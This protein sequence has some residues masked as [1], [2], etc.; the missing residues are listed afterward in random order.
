MTVIEAFDLAGPLPH[1]RLAIE[2]SAGTGKTFTLATLAARYVAEDGVPIGELLIVTFTRAAAAELKDRVR[3][4]LV[5]F[6]DALE[7]ATEPDDRLLTQIRSEDRQ[8]RLERVRTAI[9][10]FDAATITTI[11]GFA[12]QVI[13]TLGSTVLTD[14]D[15]VLVDDTEA[16]GR[17]VATDL[18]VAEAVHEAHPADEIPSLAALRRSSQLALNN[19]ESV[20]LP[21]HDPDESSPRAARLRVLV[22]EIGAE[23]DRR[24]KAAGT[25]AFDDLLSRLRDALHDELAGRG[26]REA[27]RRRYRVALIDEFQDTDPV[28]WA[29]FDTVFGLAARHYD[30]ADVTATTMVLVGDPKQAI[31][32]FRGANVHTYIEAAHA[33]DTHLTGLGVNWRS[34]PAVL[35]ATQTL[36]SGVTFGSDNI[37]FQPVSAPPKHEGRTFTTTDGTPIPALS[38]R[39]TIGPNVARDK[40]HGHLSTATN[41]EGVIHRELATHIR[42]LLE[43]A[44][45]PDGDNNGETRAL[46]PDDV[47]VLIA[48]NREGP[49]IRDALMALGIP[50]VITRGD[51]VLES[52][53]S[54]HFH[55]LLAAVARPADVRRARAA[56]LSWFFG[57]DA[58]RVAAA[59]DAELSAVQVQL[60][61]WGETLSGRGVAA[62]VGQVWAET[63]VASRVLALPDGDRAMTDLD[64]IAE[65]LSLS[66]GRQASPTTL[67][68]TFETLAGGGDD[69]NPEAD[70]AARRVESESRAVQ[71][72]TTFVAKGLEYPVVCCTS[73][74]F[75]SGAKARDNIWWD[76]ATKRRT[77]DVATH[78]KWGPDDE[79]AER[80]MLAAQ[81]AVGSHLRVLYV[82]L[83]RARHHTAVWWLPTKADWKTGL[84]RVLFARDETGTIDPDLFNCAELDHIDVDESLARLQP[85]VDV[86]DGELEVVVVD[87]PGDSAEPWT[88]ASTPDRVELAVATLDHRLDR[89]RRRWSFT[90]ITDRTHDN[91]RS[92]DPFDETAG[93]AD[94]TD[95]G[96]TEAWLSGPAD[97]MGYDDSTSATDRADAPLPLGDI[98]GG[99]GFGTLVHEVLE[100]ID[101]TVAD[102]TTEIAE[103]VTDRLAWNPWPV[104]EQRLV[105][106]LEAVVRTPL[107]P[108]FAGRALAD[109]APADRLDEMSF[110]LTLGEGGNRATDADIGRLLLDHLPPEDPLG[111]WAASLADGPFSA[112]LAGHLTG[113]ID[114]V[115]RVRHDDGV[116]RF[117]VSDYKTNR[118]AASG[119]T[120]SA[121][122]FRPDQLPTAMAEHHYPLQ[123][124]LYSVAL[125]RY[126]R[127]RLPAYDPAVHLGGSAYLFV[128]G[129]VGPDTP[130]TDGVPN[131]VFNWRPASELVIGL[132]D[133]LDGSAGTVAP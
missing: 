10:E 121:V 83:T 113:S 132:S 24:R 93:D 36:L 74:W 123:A 9:T 80:E 13:G 65:L 91:H 20:L 115:A 50:A 17:Q 71:I 51:N 90:A 130:T 75:P 47:A 133:L 116:D 95:E 30:T 79:R 106:G 5:E 129:M 4:R 64:H 76:A 63:S 73:L 108:L 78:E 118:L 21:S 131:G 114:L 100:I 94:A 61:S 41:G 42:D 126:L 81:E 128:R 56:G 124:L 59:T 67:L 89:E 15:A 77:I 23:V 96:P 44:V 11:H 70:L 60:H 46:R 58:A 103:A 69:G 52:E 62:F 31:Y 2:A 120:P 87:D 32:A 18:L 117:V 25:L 16:I 49:V 35:R 104:D 101:F 68:T 105:V 84:A 8:L 107:G 53:A 112:V 85:L 45:V 14:P 82:A 54:T 6:A 43:T 29:I 55:R 12:Q 119:V 40:K 57:W 19:P 27:L 34:D 3:L 102:L 92:F 122:H 39:L 22:D 7:S 38:V 1:G 26:A 99:A 127:W 97:L 28:Q 111:Q 66:G 86:S 48:A 109:L 37:G 88:G 33:P 72:M 125:H 98:V 110:D